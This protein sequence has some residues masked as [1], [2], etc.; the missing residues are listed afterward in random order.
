LSGLRLRIVATIGATMLVT[1][2]VAFV[3]VYRQTGSE[4]HNQLKAAL[5]GSAGQLAGAVRQRPHATADSALAAAREFA[6]AQSYSNASVLLF[7]IVPGHG[8]A[9]NHPELFGAA[10]PDSDESSAEQRAENAQG[11]R[12]AIPRPGFAYQPAP[13]TG[14]LLTYEQTIKLADGVRLYAGAAEPVSGIAKAQHG[15]RRSYLLAGA[16]A[17]MLAL[18]GAFIAGSRMAAPL[19]RVATMAE[20]IDAGD[21]SPRM[22]VP[23]SASR[24]VRVLA[25]AFNHMLDRLRD[26]FDA[27]QEFV[28]DASHE[29]RTPLTVIRGQLDLLAG[30][31]T[32]SSDDLNRMERII[33][34]E[35]ARMSRL[36]DDLLL[37]AQSGESDFLRPETVALA[38][39]V[40]ELWDGLSLTADRR[41][42][43]GSLPDA[44]LRA[45]PDRLAQALRNLGRNAIDH[46]REH[47]GLVRIDVA[48]QPPAYGRPAFVRFTISDDGPGIRPEQRSRVFE[49][50]YR[51]DAARTRS[52]GGAG[53]GLAIV[54]AIAVA[55][56]GTVSAGKSSAGGAA[57]QLDLP[58]RVSPQPSKKALTHR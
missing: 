17:L 40:S 13:D 4:L 57:M 27:Q 15:V 48:L 43:I 5:R 46:T 1:L 50:F 29:L 2:A 20:Q 18:I 11:R 37:L 30:T 12:L 6:R 39:F 3:I 45:D 14:L 47:D 53:L 36:T 16:V 22:S 49:R 42:E 34:S 24:E 32:V 33:D 35:V 21:L 38:P 10:K 9:S 7:A 55:H 19:R 25:Q 26:A 51:T 52:A 8:T 56:G 44:E 54:H 41:F 31:D 23:A 58:F 28:A